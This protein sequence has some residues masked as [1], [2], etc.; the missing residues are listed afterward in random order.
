MSG[1]GQN[2]VAEIIPTLK[3]FGK[4][5]MTKSHLDGELWPNASLCIRLPDKPEHRTTSSPGAGS[6]ASKGAAKLMV[7]LFMGKI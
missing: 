5:I 4:N 1:H 3:A 2:F 7:D 6:P